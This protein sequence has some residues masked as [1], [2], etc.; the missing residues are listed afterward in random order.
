L[1]AARLQFIHHFQVQL[2]PRN[3]DPSHAGGKFRTVPFGVHGPMSRNRR[4]PIAATVALLAALIAHNAE[5]SDPL[6]VP[7]D[8]AM[9]MRLPEKVGTIVIGNPLIA[10]VTLQ[11]G[12]LVIVTGKGYGTTNLVALDRDGNVLLERPITVVG[13]KDNVLVVYRGNERQTYSCEPRCERRITLGDGADA[14]NLSISQS[15][16]RNARAGGQ[17]EGAR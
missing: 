1:R 13:A 3:A 2:A 15:A 12:G 8:E 10:D 16:A 17:G 14:F 4:T 9:L 5:A 7:V 6:K 11:S